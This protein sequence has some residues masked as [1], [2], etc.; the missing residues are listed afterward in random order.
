MRI[1][2]L[3]AP[4]IVLSL[5]L[6]SS[7]PLVTPGPAAA[8]TQAGQSVW[9][10]HQVDDGGFNI[11]LP[12]TVDRRVNSPKILGNTTEQTLLL[13]SQ[14]QHNAFYM[15]AW[16][17]LSV[18][19]NLSETDQNKVLELARESFLRSF[20]GQLSE[21]IQLRLSGNPGK[22]FAMVS[23]LQGQPFIIRSRSFLVGSRLYHILAAV[24]QNLD[25]S[26]VGSTEG[27]LR[28]FQLQ[29]SFLASVNRLAQGDAALAP[30]WQLQ[31]G[32][33]AALPAAADPAAATPNL[34]AIPADP[35]RLAPLVEDP[36][37]RRL[38]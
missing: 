28:S 34:E 31:P 36:A 18:N 32:N 19:S 15:V 37:A 10:A 23:R 38:F 26:L 33:G 5:F 30:A 8:K 17:D 14:A 29:P 9:S 21:D 22:Q 3:A 25:R 7:I 2:A 12:G 16:S 11:L 20:K 27:F 35:A 6:G 24:P 13:A 4:L 1:P